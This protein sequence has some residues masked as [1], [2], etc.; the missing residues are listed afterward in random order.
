[1]T[2][3]RGRTRKA[4]AWGRVGRDSE[5]G[6]VLGRSAG[7][8]SPG[9]SRPWRE[10]LFFLSERRSLGRFSSS[11]RLAHGDAQGPLYP[12]R[13]RYRCHRY[14]LLIPGDTSTAPPAPPRRGPPP[15]HRGDFVGTALPHRMTARSTVPGVPRSWA[16]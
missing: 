12:P 8:A 11:K 3:P 16:L 2:R 10:L 15:R 1:M 4:C 14:A 13:N 5:A 9:P 7:P 6:T